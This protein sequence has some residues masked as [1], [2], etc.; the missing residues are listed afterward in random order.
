MALKTACVTF[1]GC[2]AV[3]AAQAQQQGNPNIIP[4]M[5]SLAHL[6]PQMSLP[7]SAHAVSQPPSMLGT[8]QAAPNAASLP[9]GFPS[10]VLAPASNG[11][12][13]MPWPLVS[14][15]A[16]G[17]QAVP[18]APAVPS[19]GLNPAQAPAVQPEAAQPAEA[20]AEAPSSGASGAHLEGQAAQ[21]QGGAQQPAMQ[22]ASDAQD[23]V[24]DGV[25]QLR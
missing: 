1:G 17:Y 25:G 24:Q 21:P 4:L 23:D 5:H 13:A 8:P 20:Q 22:P 7:G 10:F 15:P 18:P 2:T 16:Q 19:P 6:M 14:Q 11:A 9:P 12:S 3:A